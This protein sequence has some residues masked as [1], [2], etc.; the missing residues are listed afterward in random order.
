MP[1]QQPLRTES[2]WTQS[3]RRIPNQ[4]PAAET[5]GQE[6]QKASRPAGEATVTSLLPNA[7]DSRR[8]CLHEAIWRSREEKSE[9]RSP[10]HLLNSGYGI[11]EDDPS[12]ILL[13]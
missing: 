3:H 12:S 5:R 11:P 4:T 6:A 13:A 10:T 8:I 9:S 2:A 7:Q 1:P